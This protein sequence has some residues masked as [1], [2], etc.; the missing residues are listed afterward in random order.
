MEKAISKFENL[1]KAVGTKVMVYFMDENSNDIKKQVLI[2][3]QEKG[4]RPSTMTQKN[5]Q[6]LHAV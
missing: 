1:S 5:A 3:R 4:K 2:W 6:H